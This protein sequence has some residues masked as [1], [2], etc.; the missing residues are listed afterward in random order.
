MEDL[1]KQRVCKTAIAC[2]QIY[3]TEFLDYN[4]LVCSKAF[5]L[6]PFYIINA[7]A[8]NF[9]HLLGVHSFEE[10]RYK[11]EDIRDEALRERDRLIKDNKPF[12]IV[13]YNADI[14]F[15]K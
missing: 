11:A 8:D 14:N 12:N 3:K 10:W 6:K 4:Y 2:A 7:H 1:F 13:K 9:Q 5:T 15:I